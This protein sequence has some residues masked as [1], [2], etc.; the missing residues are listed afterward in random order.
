M[1]D[2][3][4]SISGAMEMSFEAMCDVMMEILRQWMELVGRERARGEIEEKKAATCCGCRRIGGCFSW[5]GGATPSSPN[6]PKNRTRDN[7]VW[8]SPISTYNRCRCSNWDLSLHSWQHFPVPHGIASS[9]S[10]LDRSNLPEPSI[11][12][13]L[14]HAIE[15]IH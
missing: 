3:I 4:Q 15:S 13:H 1:L 2:A 9:Y 5:Q 8:C 10:V 11:H 7:D 6:I 14:L 12:V